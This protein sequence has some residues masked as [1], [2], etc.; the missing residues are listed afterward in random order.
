ML[1]FLW[2]ISGRR[3]QK[4]PSLSGSPV[5]T[6]SFF[7]STS[8]P[9]QA[10][11]IWMMGI[12]PSQRSFRSWW[13]FFITPFTTVNMVSDGL[14]SIHAP[15]R[16][17]LRIFLFPT[18]ESWWDSGLDY[19]HSLFF[20]HKSQPLLRETWVPHHLKVGQSRS[21]GFFSPRL[22]LEENCKQIKIVE[23][24]YSSSK[25]WKNCWSFTNCQVL[26]SSLF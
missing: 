25:L 20:F 15:L 6:V 18:L 24:K 1:S 14:P 16:L 21:S 17:A 23:N 11:W 13:A 10:N 26:L 5:T 8:L 4:I 19:T 3:Y 12:F 22:H 9:R 2:I 7:L